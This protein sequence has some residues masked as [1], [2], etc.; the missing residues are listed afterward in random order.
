MKAKFIAALLELLDE[1]HTPR[2]VNLRQISRRIGCAHTNAYNYFDSFESLLWHSL[3]EIIQKMIAS[4][5][6]TH[7]KST[8]STI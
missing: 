2:S 4:C 5:G 7:L 8:V 6:A 1:E 3:A